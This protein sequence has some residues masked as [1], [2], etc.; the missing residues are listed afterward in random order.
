MLNCAFSPYTAVVISPTAQTD[1]SISSSA[2]SFIFLPEKKVQWG[3]SHISLTKQT[4]SPCFL[5]SNHHINQSPL[6]GVRI[7]GFWK[8][9][10]PH[11][12]WYLHG[13][14]KEEV[15]LPSPPT[16][17]GTAP[18]AVFIYLTKS[19][20]YQDFWYKFQMKAPTRWASGSY[21]E[22]PL[23]LVGAYIHLYQMADLS[24][25]SKQQCHTH[26]LLWSFFQKRGCSENFATQHK[27][28]A[29]KPRFS[30]KPKQTCLRKP[31]LM[32]K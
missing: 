12:I 15:P 28:N 19:Y 18:Q 7:R 4:F 13:W 11:H 1:H 30:V 2:Y 23:T 17:F 10:H 24:W 9:N 25:N 5:E 3:H 27:I 16:T 26:L 22:H 14:A 20:C 29:K 21:T 32:N 8:Q 6:P 31:F